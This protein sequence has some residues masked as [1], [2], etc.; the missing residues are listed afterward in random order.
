MKDIDKLMKGF[1]EQVKEIEKVF[2]GLKQE[3]ECPVDFTKGSGIHTMGLAFQKNRSELYKEMREPTYCVYNIKNKRLFIKTI[4]VPITKENCKANDWVFVTND[5]TT[6]FT[7][8][9]N[10]KLCLEDEI[11]SYV[12]VESEYKCNR[13]SLSPDWKYY[14]KVIEVKDEN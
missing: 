9:Y 11:G 3:I 8:K 13:F 5:E 12:C 7:D 4:L 14:Y 1:R 10:Y 6:N 2:A